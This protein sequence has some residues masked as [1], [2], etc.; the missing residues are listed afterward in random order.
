MA[1]TS[2]E[3]TSEEVLRMLVEKLQKEGSLRG[4]GTARIVSE[5]RDKDFAIIVSID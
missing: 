4:A 1:R 2:F 3:F 5:H